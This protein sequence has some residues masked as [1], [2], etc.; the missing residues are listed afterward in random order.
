MPKYFCEYCDI[1]LAHS[2]PGARREH[3]SGK[4][5]I[6]NKIAY[7][8]NLLNQPG[9]VPPTYLSDQQG[10]SKV[11]SGMGHPYN[12]YMM[13]DGMPN[14]YTQSL[15][16]MNTMNMNMTGYNNQT[17]RVPQTGNQGSYPDKQRGHG[18]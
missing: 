8:Q 3:N 17:M 13:P 6:T 10:Q 18:A 1:K 7:F 2:S 11:M 14:N 12:M 9:F 16:T 15:Y 5:H 4:K